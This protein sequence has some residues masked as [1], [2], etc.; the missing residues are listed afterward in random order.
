MSDGVWI[1]SLP[2][3]RMLDEG[4]PD[5]PQN[6]AGQMRALPRRSLPEPS[7]E[8]SAR[9]GSHGMVRDRQRALRRA[10]VRTSERARPAVP[11]LR[12]AVPVRHRRRLLPALRC[13]ERGQA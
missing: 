9:L 12:R 2:T 13:R 3:G 8:R 6:L 5:R 11:C 10:A 7:R 4:A 1:S